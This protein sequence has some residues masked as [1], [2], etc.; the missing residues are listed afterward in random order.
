MV[1]EARNPSKGQ[2]CGRNPLPLGD[3]G[4]TLDDL[5]VVLES[6]WGV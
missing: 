6:L 3:L 2:L 4:E 5:K 1:P